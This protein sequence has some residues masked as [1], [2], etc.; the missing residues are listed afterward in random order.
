M[1][2]TQSK[3]GIFPSQPVSQPPVRT[4][5]PAKH[6]G[7][8]GKYYVCGTGRQ[9]ILRNK[10]GKRQLLPLTLAAIAKEIQ[11]RG[12]KENAVNL[13]GSALA[14]FGREKKAFREYSPFFPAGKPKFEGISYQS[15]HSGRQTFSTERL[16]RI[17]IHCRRLVQG[18]P[19]CSLWTSGELGK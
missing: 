13:S 15:D 5:Y 6:A 9:S 16:L 2:T 7:I 18:E 1:G 14:G 19:S 10:N 11:Q 3:P 8:P 4:I 12:E 17:A